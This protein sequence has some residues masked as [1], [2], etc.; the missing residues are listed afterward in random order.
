MFT[1]PSGGGVRFCSVSSSAWH[2]TELL[3]HFGDIVPNRFLSISRFGFGIGTRFREHF[4]A[5][6]REKFL[7]NKFTEVSH[8]TLRIPAGGGR[9]SWLFTQR[10]GGVQ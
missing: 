3:S 2:V 1:V 6:C 10:S 5:S 7:K 4:Q 8:M 9:T